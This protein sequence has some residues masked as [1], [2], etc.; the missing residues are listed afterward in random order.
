MLHAT[1]PPVA[2]NE[3]GQGGPPPESK[4]SVLVPAA[5]T[6]TW[7]QASAAT[8]T[9]CESLTIGSAL[10]ATAQVRTFQH[11]RYSN[12]T[13]ALC[14]PGAQ[15]DV[16]SSSCA[17]RLGLRFLKTD[18]QL[19][20]VDGP[21]IIRASGIAT[22]GICARNADNVLMTI[23]LLL[24]PNMSMILPSNSNTLP[25]AGQLDL[26]D[27][28]YMVPGKV[29]IILGAGTLAAL[30]EETAPNRQPDGCIA[31]KTR[32]GWIVFGPTQSG[33]TQSQMRS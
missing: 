24:V 25:I 29:E 22:V 15:V 1:E 13:R 26:A 21:N 10:L 17:Q 20:G 3:V 31:L 16:I 2:C 30:L 7:S 6:A 4:P 11:G 8:P 27:P 14:D 23:K 18:A 19:S 12:N 9:T 5:A 33:S 28:S 32:L